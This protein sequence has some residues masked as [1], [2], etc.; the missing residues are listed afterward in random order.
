MDDVYYKLLIVFDNMTT[1]ML[2]N[3]KINSVAIE[4]FIRG[5]KLN[6][7]FGFITQSFFALLRNIRLNSTHCFIVEILNKREL[8]HNSFNHL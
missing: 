7:S 4:S 8:Q 2:I 1:D 6:I 3:K 5:R